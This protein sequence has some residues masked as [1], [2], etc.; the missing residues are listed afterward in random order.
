MHPNLE[1]STMNFLLILLTL[2]LTSVVFVY[3]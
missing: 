2:V 3:L 1:E